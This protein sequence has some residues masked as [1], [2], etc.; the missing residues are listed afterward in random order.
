MVVIFAGP[1]GSGKST[2]F[3]MLRGDGVL[4]A[5]FIKGTRVTGR[6]NK[7]IRAQFLISKI[8][9]NDLVIYDRAT[10]LDDLVYSKII[11]HTPSP[12]LEIMGYEVYNL[13]DCLIIYFTADDDILAKRLTERGDEY[14]KVEDI[15]VIKEGYNSVFDEL[16]LEPVIIDT[17]HL[18]EMAVSALVLEEVLAYE[19]R[20]NS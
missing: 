17:S 9:E 11:D 13:R 7:M 5:S 4:N 16:G 6:R 1:D 2:C 19:E 3:E 15:P 18:S 10:L 20:K 14:I 12:M 8:P